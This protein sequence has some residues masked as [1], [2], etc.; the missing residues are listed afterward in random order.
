MLVGDESTLSRPL[1]HAPNQLV[2]GAQLPDQEHV[3][4][5]DGDNGHFH[6]AKK[7]NKIMRTNY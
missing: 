5:A 2:V 3:Q 4:Q 7:N 1:G 6:L